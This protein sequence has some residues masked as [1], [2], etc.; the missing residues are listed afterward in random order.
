MTTTGR[1]ADRVAVVTGAAQGI[2]RSYAEALA[3]AGA[4]VCV[5]DISAPEETCEAIRSAGGEAVAV[6]ADVTSDEALHSLAS[7]AL[8]AFG[9]ISVLVNNAAL[10]GNLTTKPFT[11]IDCDEW[12]LV[13][14]VNVR[15]TWQ[16]IK[17]VAPQMHDGGSIVNISSGTVFKGSPFLLHYV[18]S[19]G[20]II[21]LTRS[22]ARE[23]GD[24]QIRVNAIAPGVV[25]SDN[26]RRNPAYSQVAATAAE[27]RALKRAALPDDVVGTLLYLASDDSAFLTGQTIVVDGGSIMH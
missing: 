3:A 6:A 14:K 27:T 2:G 9:R 12:D 11:E 1:L 19:K 20:A 8:D 23:L 4:K 7:A 21:A 26:L 25:M 10:F 16:A 22:A 18:A 15:G 5:S 24:R 17:A 13:M